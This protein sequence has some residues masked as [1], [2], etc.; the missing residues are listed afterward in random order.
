MGEIGR[1]A[2]PDFHFHSILY[3]RRITVQYHFIATADE[4][5]QDESPSDQSIR[6]GLMY[7][8]TGSEHHM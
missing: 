1:S 3:V 6:L 5:L 8:R 7:V 4:R 2:Q